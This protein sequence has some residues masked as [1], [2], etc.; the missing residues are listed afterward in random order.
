MTV[1]TTVL[2]VENLTTLLQTSA[3]DVAVVDG[4]TFDLKKGTTLAI[5]GESGC[6]KSMTALSIMRILPKPPALEPTG[7]VIYQG[8]D[9]LTLS[10]RAMRKIR[11][12]S[13]A[14]IFQDPMTA[15]NPVYTIGY[16][17]FEVVNLHLKMYGAEA[18]E[19]IVTNLKDVGIPSPEKIVDEYPHQLSGGM[20]QRIMIAM[21][22]MCEPD[23]LIADEPTTAL[24]VTVQAQV[25]DLMKDLQERKGTAIILI[26]HDMGVVAEVADEVIV[27][28]AA[29]NVEHG[30]VH[31]VFDNMAHPYTKGLFASR[32]HKDAEKGKL[33]AIEG[34]V[35]HVSDMPSGCRFHPRCPDA[36]ERCTKENPHCT[37]LGG[38]HSVE[39]WKYN[40]EYR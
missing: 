39:C 33:T 5:V 29:K 20:K 4:I 21:A 2:R 40:E 34:M 28:Y 1:D 37:N 38:I 14:M 12:N 24:D 9:L 3:G 17:L 23:I 8:K 22:L 25:L 36:F 7:A 18:L 6:G 10:R 15:L 32:P 19:H 31:D 26:T 27:M 11:G 13:I 35:P 30:S 16:Q